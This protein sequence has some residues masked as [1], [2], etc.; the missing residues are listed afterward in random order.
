[1]SES[2]GKRQILTW[3]I[4]YQDLWRREA[5][6]WRFARRAL[7]LDWTEVRTL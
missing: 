5:G 1:V 7:I 4:R 6:E 3:A 2:A